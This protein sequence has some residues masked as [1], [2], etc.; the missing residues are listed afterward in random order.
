MFLSSLRAADY[1]DTVTHAQMSPV[2]VHWSWTPCEATLRICFATAGERF[3]RPLA[4]TDW[5]WPGGERF[6]TATVHLRMCDRAVNDKW[7]RATLHRND[8]NEIHWS[9]TNITFSNQKALVLDLYFVSVETLGF[10]AQ[11]QIEKSCVWSKVWHIIQLHVSNLH[12][13]KLNL[14][15][16]SIKVKKK[17]SQWISI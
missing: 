1:R 9:K 2:K 8:S 6:A 5:K 17:K 13:S 11:Y 10:Q 14:I 16:S 15:Y 7:P 12:F 4:R 3:T